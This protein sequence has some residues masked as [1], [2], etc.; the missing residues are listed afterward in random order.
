MSKIKVLHIAT[1]FPTNE[2]SAITP[3]MLKL[4]LAQRELG[5]DVRVFTS[6]YKGQKD[7][8]VFDIPVYRFR[9][10]NASLENITYESPIYETVRRN[11]LRYLQ[12]PLFFIGGLIKAMR[13]DWKPDI[14]HIH[15]PIPFIVFSWAF[16]KTPKVLNYHHSELSVLRKFKFL[17][18]FFRRQLRKA[19]A[20]LC[21]SKFTKGKFLEMFP[22]LT[23][24]V[25][26]MPL[27]I[28]LPDMAEIHNKEQG[29]VLFV[30]RMVYWKG[31]DLL[32]KAMKILKDRGIRAKLVMVGDGFDKDKWRKMAESMGIDAEFT[33]YLVG[34]DLVRQYQRASIF[35]LPSRFDPKVWTESLGVVLIEAMLYGSPVVAPHVGGPIEVVEDSKAG[36][37]FEVESFE[38]LADKLEILIENEKTRREMIANGIEYAQGFTPISVAK[39]MQQVYEKFLE[40]SNDDNN[41]S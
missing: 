29:R 21:N 35:A 2:D 4:I 10:S 25:I 22:K 15:W 8:K 40:N 27:S 30:G 20:H 37:T 14:L 24:N 32:L 7:G 28:S 3:W 6:A 41:I 1:A 5:M 18:P 19:K 23:A 13:M 12:V 9:Y 36:Y 34:D 26:P 38:E 17:K 39:K 11:P 16:K 33:G 31:G